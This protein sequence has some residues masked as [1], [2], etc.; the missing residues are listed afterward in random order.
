MLR[1]MRRQ[2]KYEEYKKRVPKNLRSKMSFGEYL[3]HSE[4]VQTDK[5]KL[6]RRMKLR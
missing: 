5:K 2:A 6:R 3:K 1:K 4:E